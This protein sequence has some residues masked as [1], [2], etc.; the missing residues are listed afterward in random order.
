MTST[1][2]KMTRPPVGSMSEYT[3]IKC[4]DVKPVGSFSPTS[5]KRSFYICK[6]C[7]NQLS[8]DSCKRDIA[9]RIIKRL[10]SRKTPLRVDAVR[11]LLQEYSAESD[12][13][14]FAVENDNV[15]IRKRR[16]DEPL[17][18]EGNAV[19]VPRSEASKRRKTGVSR[20]D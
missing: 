7:A 8:I 10:N 2:V 14:K 1:D 18:A 5:L 6:T 4:K 15:D 3:C 9:L 19:V 11:R 13:N 20:T 16:A 12:A 17:N